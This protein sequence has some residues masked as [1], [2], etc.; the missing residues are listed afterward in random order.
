MNL[1]KTVNL[2]FFCDDAN[3]EYGLTHPETVDQGFNAFWNGIGIFHDVFEH[4]HEHNHKYFKD[5]YA[6]NVG[7]EMAAMGAM[8]Y[9]FDTLGVYNRLGNTYKPPDIVTRDTTEYMIHEAIEDGWCNFGSELRCNVP[10][11]KPVFNAT[12]EDIIASFKINGYRFNKRPNFE[13]IDY[14]C[15]KLYQKSVTRSKIARLHRYGYRMAERLVPYNWKNEEILSEFLDFW[16]KFGK[17]NP[18]EELQHCYKGITFRIY[19]EKGII[20]WTATLNPLYR[21]EMKS[22][23]L[24]SESSTRINLEEYMYDYI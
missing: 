7:G 8:W 6:M 15:S 10:Y 4:S 3:G 13:D 16:E 23:K 22:I 17:M 2:I 18:A 14:Q 5:D 12:L 24:N 9:Y 1:I 21:N 11:Q 20:K 19:K